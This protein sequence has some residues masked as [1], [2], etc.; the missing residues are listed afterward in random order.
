MFKRKTITQG[1]NSISGLAGGELNQTR[2]EEA[3]DVLVPK[4]AELD[5]TDR[6]GGK[7]ISI[8]SEAATTLDLQKELDELVEAENVFPEDEMFVTRRGLPPCKRVRKEG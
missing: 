4:G 8:E 3:M 2:L 6:W 7:N 1:L 5:T